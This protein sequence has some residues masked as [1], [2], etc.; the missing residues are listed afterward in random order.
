MSQKGCSIASI[1]AAVKKNTEIILSQEL[2]IKRNTEAILSLKR[3][4]ETYSVDIKRKISRL[5]AFCD[6]LPGV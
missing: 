4:L 1:E 3:E 5:A 2:E 6:S